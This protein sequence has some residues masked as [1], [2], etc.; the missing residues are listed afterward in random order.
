MTRPD[1]LHLLKIRQPTLSFRTR[2]VRRPWRTNTT[3]HMSRIPPR[4][5]PSAAACP[6]SRCI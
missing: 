3:P 4:R 2:R 1:I 6:R 5:P